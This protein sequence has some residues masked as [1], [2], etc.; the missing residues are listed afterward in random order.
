MIRSGVTG[1]NGEHRQVVEYQ[2][3]L[4]SNPEFTASA[5]VSFAR[6]VFRM[7]SRGRT[8]CLTVLDIAP[9]DLSPLPGE[10]LRAHML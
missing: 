4:D 8:G 9:A 5:L 2:L 1:Q 7:K 10:E 3:R 6:A